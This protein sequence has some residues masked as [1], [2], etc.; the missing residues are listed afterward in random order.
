M[1]EEAGTYQNRSPV[2]VVPASRIRRGAP[3]AKAPSTPAVPAEIPISALPEMTAC[4]VSP[5]PFVYRISRFNPCFLKM[6]ALWPTS[7]KPLSQ[8]LGAPT[9]TLRRS[10]HSAAV[11]RRVTRKKTS[12]TRSIWMSSRMPALRTLAVSASRFRCLDELIKVRRADGDLADTH[13]VGP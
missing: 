7:G 13:V 2:P 6:P 8:L 9:A 1:G 3:L 5:P 10:S 4:I 12:S 11:E